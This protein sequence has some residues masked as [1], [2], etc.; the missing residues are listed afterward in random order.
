MKNLEQKIE[1]KVCGADQEEI[2]P[3]FIKVPMIE[4]CICLSC[5]YIF[6]NPSTLH[7][8]RRNKE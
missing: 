4:F 5:G 7:V 8:V 6:V 1:C 3:N 2:H